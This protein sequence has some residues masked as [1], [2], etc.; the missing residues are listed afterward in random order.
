M[1]IEQLLTRHGFPAEIKD[2]LLAAGIQDL[3]P[4]QAEAIAQGV[5]DGKNTLLSVPTAAGKTLIAELC[6]IRSLLNHRG[7]C[8]YIV[9]LKALAAEKYETFRQRYASLGIKVGLATGDSP[10]ANNVYS[11]YH[12][13]IAT[14]EKVDTFLRARA[15]WLLQQLNVVVLDEIHLINDPERGPTLEIIAAR[16][17]QLSPATQILALSATAQN[18]DQLADW[19]SAGLVA[20]TWR[21]IP[22]REGIMHQRRLTFPDDQER[23]LRVKRGEPDDLNALIAD[24]LQ[25]QGQALVFVNSRRSAQTV[26]RQISA[27]VNA[28]LSS[29]ER[30]RLNQLADAVLGAE[31][32]TT[33]LCRQLA[34]VIRQGVAFH[35]AGLR[36]R[37]RR[38]IE[39][40][41]KSHLLRVICA[42]PTLAAG[43]NLPARRAI[44]RDVKR[45]SGRGSHFIPVAEY[46]QCAGRAGRPGYDQSG[47]ALIL[48]KTSAEVPAMLRRYI[49][50][51]PEPITSKLGTDSALRTHILASIAGGFVHDI[52]DTFQ[53][54][55]H[56]FLS[57]QRQT[58]QLIEMIGEIFDF[59]QKEEFI[60]KRGFRFFA[61]P[62]GQYTSRLYLDPASAII[63][64]SGLSLI[65][66]GKS[67]SNIG[68][69]HMINCC[70][71]SPLLHFGKSDLEELDKFMSACQDEL[72]LTEQDLPML[73]DLGLNMAIMKTT[74]MLTRWI[75]EN[76]EE[77]I[78][79]D[80]NIGP[81]DIYRHMEAS[82]WL[83]TAAKT[84]SELFQC[85]HL[86]PLLTDLA[87]RVRYG[88]KEELLPLCRLAG[89][90]RVRARNLYQAGFCGIPDLKAASAEDLA[91]VDKISPALAQDILKQ[92]TLPGQPSAA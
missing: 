87:S 9:P 2:I 69:L 85:A 15:Q 59:L 21:P 41:F 12:I 38:L 49:L 3:F 70:P 44:I 36:P 64:R 7:H 79:Q 8:L 33:R 90:G 72:V 62:F 91:R 63:L 68:I 88:I 16:I 74:L 84:Y 61:T 40:H 57:H 6:M 73:T 1:N 56:T 11:G 75:E 45:F 76:R 58:S 22:L 82:R 51:A 17:R 39:D 37:Q 43:V 86:G 29:E 78:C 27:R 4:P 28:A 66:A 52:H 31:T 60:E 54:L 13:L 26:S 47:E 65:A 34:E 42:T 50:A 81:G 24:T 55:S 46:K 80:F 18:A 92:L 67:F 89:I 35:H 10:A 5:L 32:E 23:T 20:S 19:L 83:L 71:N 25:D 30:G 53:F 14:A 77:R 48:A